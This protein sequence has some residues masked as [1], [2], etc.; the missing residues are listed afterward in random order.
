MPKDALKAFDTVKLVKGFGMRVKGLWQ[1]GRTHIMSVKATEAIQ[2][3]QPQK[4]GWTLGSI[5]L[6]TED[7]W[8]PFQECLD[9]LASPADSR[10]TLTD[11]ESMCQAH[12]ASQRVHRAQAELQHIQQENT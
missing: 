6:L 11:S 4:K 8:G 1:N 7:P 12:P 2:C 10:K 9:I 3:P 5:P